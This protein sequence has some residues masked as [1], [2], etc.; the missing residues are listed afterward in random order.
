MKFLRNRPEF[1]LIPAIFVV[2]TLLWENL[3]NILEVDEVVL[4]TP[5]RIGSALVAQ[6][7][8]P[9]FWLNL[10][11]TSQEALLGFAAAVIF[12]IIAGTF[13]SQIKIVD[14][15]FMPYLVG[16]QAIPKIALAP[17]FIVWFGYGMSSK[18]VMAA[19]VAFFPILVNIIEG[20]KS[21]DNEQIR[22]L[23][24]F[25]ASRFQIFLKVQ[26]PCALPFFFAGLD[27]GILLAI[28]GAVVGEFLGSQEGLGA[29][30]LLAQY[31]FEIPTMFAILIVLS[32]MGII[33]HIIVKALQRKFAF[34]GDSSNF[35]GN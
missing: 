9:L 33:S 16:F 15:A 6:L 28:L 30:V 19:T 25:G 27:V 7:D 31:N 14:K 12:A 2:F 3:V 8:N 11:V 1:I 18:V 32:L 17:I 4:P 21:A 22:M 35:I 10:R 24:V 13:I 29:M 20:L 26:I 5:T 23:R 34:W